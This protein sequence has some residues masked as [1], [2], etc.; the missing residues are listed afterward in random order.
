[1]L[2]KNILCRTCIAS[3]ASV[4]FATASRTISSIASTVLRASSAL[5]LDS[6]KVVS[7]SKSNKKI[8]KFVKQYS[9]LTHST[10]HL[11]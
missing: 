2:M 11:F 7:K 6:E 9:L 5:V 4:V 1:M 10:I 3:L 8:Q